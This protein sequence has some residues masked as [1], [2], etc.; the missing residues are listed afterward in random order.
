MVSPYATR[1]FN[2]VHHSKL[3]MAVRDILIV[4][5]FSIFEGFVHYI[6]AGLVSMSNREHL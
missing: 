4:L 1:E 6:F 2:F 3:I 5:V